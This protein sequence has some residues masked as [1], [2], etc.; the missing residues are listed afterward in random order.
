VRLVDNADLFPDGRRAFGDHFLQVPAIPVELA[1][2]AFAFAD[3]AHDRHETFAIVF[4]GD[5]LQKDLYG[6]QASILVAM[7]RLESLG[8]ARAA[9]QRRNHL[10]ETRFVVF[11]FDVQHGHAFQFVRTV[12]DLAHRTGIGIE[13]PQVVR[14]EHEHTIECLVQCGLEAPEFRLG[15]HQVGALA[16]HA[17]V[18]G[19]DGMA[20]LRVLVAARGQRGQRNT[21]LADARQHP[22]GMPQR[23]QGP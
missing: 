13:K 2:D 4:G 23:G 16:L 9:D 17:P 20:E 19:F 18:G 21:A 12:P 22:D 1:L 5:V 11:G 14:R 6:N 10:P 8:V 15:R 7:H 3:V